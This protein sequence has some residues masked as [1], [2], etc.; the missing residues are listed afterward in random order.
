MNTSKAEYRVLRPDFDLEGI[1]TWVF[2]IDN[3][4]Y[5]ARCDLFTEIHQR[6]AQFVA[7]SLSISVD[8]AKKV[9]RKYFMA[10]GTTMQGMMHNHG[11]DPEHYMAYVHDIDYS[12]LQPD[13]ALREAIAALPGRKL[14]FTNASL[15][16]GEKCAQRLGVADLFDGWFDIRDAGFAPKPA[17]ATYR[18]FEEKFSVGGKSTVFFEDTLKNLETSTALGWQ[19]VF[20]D[21]S[22][23][24]AEE[25]D[26]DQGRA[27][28]RRVAD[29]GYVHA[30]STGL[31]EFFGAHS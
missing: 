25:F 13:P 21:P 31:A 15:E 28:N 11:T 14:I 4:L 1:D 2:D 29:A 24:L 8:Q 12:P 9:R 20:V 10:H 5:P 19:S 6:M 26:S 23:V 16:H 22:L 30:C 3:T 17:L 18:A 27:E 7:D